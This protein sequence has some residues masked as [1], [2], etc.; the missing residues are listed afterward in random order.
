MGHQII[1]LTFNIMVNG[2]AVHRI[3][4]TSRAK[5]TANAATWIKKVTGSQNVE[6]KLQAD[7]MRAD[8]VSIVRKRNNRTDSTVTQV[9]I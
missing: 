6:F 2:Q 9:T 5:A 3:E 8:S 1:M 4:S 7:R